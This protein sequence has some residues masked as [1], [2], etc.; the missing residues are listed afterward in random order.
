MHADGACGSSGTGATTKDGRGQT[1]RMY[2]PEVGVVLR[3]LRPNGVHAIMRLGCY[4]TTQTA[5]ERKTQRALRMLGR[6]VVPSTYRIRR[7]VRRERS[8][9]RRAW[10]QSQTLVSAAN[11]LPA[12]AAPQSAGGGHQTGWAPSLTIDIDGDF[13]LDV[14]A[15][16]NRRST[17]AL[18]KDDSS[19]STS[20]STSRPF[21]INGS[22]RRRVMGRRM[23]N[24]RCWSA[25]RE[26]HEETEHRE[27][28][29]HVQNARVRLCG[30]RKSNR[31][32]TVDR[33]IGSL[34]VVPMRRTIPALS[35]IVMA[36]GPK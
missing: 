5:P 25:C 12:Q 32:R 4:T 26:V 10:M 28:A 24:S 8:A 36:V 6:I 31:M 27:C 16:D 1:T 30:R 11:P 22:A 13:D 34:V 29:T 20:T 2:L 19:L 17:L 35:Y 23:G 14:D 18:V 33:W 3:V 7:P 15:I 9:L 21:R